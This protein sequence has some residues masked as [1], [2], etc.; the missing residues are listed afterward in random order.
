MNIRDLIP[1]DKFDESGI[2]GLK[3]LSFEQIRPIIPDLL[4]WLQDMNWPVARPV[5]DI[6]EPFSNRITPELVAILKST[7]VM[8]K[9]WI[10]GN[11]IKHANDP[12]ILNELERIVKYPT[13]DEIENEIHIEAASI[14]NGDYKN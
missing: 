9:Y 11:L 4:E 6:L 14:L 13:N 2:E 7:D 3:K 10:L 8:W 5:A 1:K 12:L